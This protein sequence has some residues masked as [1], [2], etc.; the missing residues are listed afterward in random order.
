MNITYIDENI[1]DANKATVR[2]PNI[3]D[4]VLVGST[5]SDHIFRIPI[6]DFFLKY[7]RELEESKVYYTIP[8]ELFYKPKLLSLQLYG[9]TELWLALLRANNMRN[10]T[11]FHYPIIE[12]YDP[13]RLTEL[14]KV[15]FKREGKF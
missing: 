11:E 12:V 15:F 14:I 2:L 10:V 1:D 3:Y 13:V 5:S 7:K 4:S 8:E 6:D 9:T